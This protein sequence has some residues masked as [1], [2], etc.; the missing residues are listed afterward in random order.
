MLTSIK[1]YLSKLIKENKDGIY[2]LIGAVSVILL[3][4]LLDIECIFRKYLNIPCLGC[5]MTRA[6]KA[7]LKG[8][9]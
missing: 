3:F 1:D 4:V 8:D 5:G 7:L 6:W 2:R 9:F